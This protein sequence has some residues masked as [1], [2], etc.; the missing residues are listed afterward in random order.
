MTASARP[1]RRADLA[2]R[3]VLEFRLA[4]D[5]AAR[6]ALA[7]VLGASAIR[8]LVFAGRLKPVQGGDWELT[9][10]LS[11]EVV[12]PCVVTLEPVVTAIDE[13]VRRLYLADPEAEPPPGSE[14]EMDADTDTEPLGAEIDPALVM[15]EA[16]A[17]ALPDFPRAAGAVLDPGLAAS[18]DPPVH[19]FAALAAL[20]KPGSD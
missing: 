8:R 10:R 17:L 20:R 18:G 6:A 1:F 16:L 13:C 12:Q 3:T 5:A 15:A 11:A 9:A 7:E 19:P 14:T 4:P 2:R